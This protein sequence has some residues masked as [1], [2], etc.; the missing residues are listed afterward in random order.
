MRFRLIIILSILFSV[1]SVKIRAQSYSEYEVKLVYLYQFVKYFNWPETSNQK[2]EFTIGLYGNYNF[3]DLADEMYQNRKFNNKPCKIIHITNPED[4]KK[5]DLVYVIGVTKFEGLQF[6]KIAKDYPVLTVG[7]QLDEFCELGGM[8]NF[9]HKDDKQ[10]LELCPPN[11]ENA[12]LQV[13]K[14]LYA[15]SRIVDVNVDEF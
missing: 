15:I 10:R 9:T 8:I 13:S 3:G 12:N 6:L 5:C 11:I 2:D 1:S 7:D 14:Q 4:S